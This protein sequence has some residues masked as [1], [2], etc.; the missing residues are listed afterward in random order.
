MSSMPEPKHEP[1]QGIAAAAVFLV[2]GGVMGG[3]AYSASGWWLISAVLITASGALGLA[4][5]VE[6]YR[7]QKEE[8]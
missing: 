2:V 8:S 1:R 6:R 3:L 7:D 4:Q 5:D